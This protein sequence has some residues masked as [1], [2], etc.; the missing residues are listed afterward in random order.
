MLCVMDEAL[1]VCLTTADAK[2]HYYVRSDVTTNT[3]VLA[4]SSRFIS[5]SGIKRLKIKDIH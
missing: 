2:C 5:T 3:Y 1:I 4:G